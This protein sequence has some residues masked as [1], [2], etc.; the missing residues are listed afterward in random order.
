MSLYIGADDL[1]AGLPEILAAPAAEGTVEL[2]VRR[3]TEGEREALDEGVLDVHEGLVGDDWVRRPTSTGRPPHPGAQLTLMNVRVI[4]LLAGEDR[5]R[6]ALAGD[7]L[8]VDLDLR[9]ENLPPGTR[10]AVGSAIVEVTDVP[11]TGCAKFTERFGQAAI[12]F[13]NGKPGR[14]LRLRGM[15]A[16]VIEGGTVRPGDSIR[17][18]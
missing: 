3:P 6:W 9:P 16:R 12:R 18:L 10:L 11:H 2:V 4:T 1:Q 15:Y 14:A 8:Y 13:V 5:D 17:K 7:Q